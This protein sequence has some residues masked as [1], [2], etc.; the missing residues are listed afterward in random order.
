MAGR[1]I[2]KLEQ[3]GKAFRRFRDSATTHGFAN[4]DLR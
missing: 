1:L 4:F 2:N 3:R